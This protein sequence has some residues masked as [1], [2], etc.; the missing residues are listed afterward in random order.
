M[1]CFYYVVCNTPQCSEEWALDGVVVP[2]SVA[3]FI[4]MIRR[5]ILKIVYMY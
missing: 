4:A 5:L 1:F 2:V 3:I